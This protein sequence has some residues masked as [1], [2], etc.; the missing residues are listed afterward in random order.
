MTR[1]VSFAE[2]RENLAKYMDEVASGGSLHIERDSSSVVMLSEDEFEGWRETIH[3]LQNA[4]N[5]EDLLKAIKAK[6]NEMTDRGTLFE[7]KR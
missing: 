2:F 7:V 4:T 5:A 1:H 6:V 3:L